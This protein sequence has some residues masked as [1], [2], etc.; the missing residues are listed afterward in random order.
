MTDTLGRKVYKL[1]LT[2]QSLFSFRCRE[3]GNPAACLSTFYWRGW[4]QPQ[5]RL[6]AIA[7]VR[8]RN[9]K[10]TGEI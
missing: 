5:V 7:L 8:A 4:N 9:E 10:K 3:T 1:L 6:R 2:Y